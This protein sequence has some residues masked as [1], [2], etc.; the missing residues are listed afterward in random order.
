M[1][2]TTSRSRMARLRPRLDQR[3]TRVIA[4]AA[5]VYLG[6]FAAG[7]ALLVNIPLARAALTPEQ[8]GVWMM[9][10]ALMG[11]FAFA[12]LG[13]GNAVL[14]GTTAALARGDRAAAH[15]IVTGGYVW[16]AAT[17]LL[18]L[19]LWLVWSRFSAAPSSV[20]GTLPAAQVGAVLSALHAFVLLLAL[21]VPAAL[22][23]KVQLAAQQGSW[24]GNTQCCA[25][26]ATLLAVPAALYV[27]GGLL[28]LVFA[29]LGMQV[30]VNTA[31]SWLWLRRERLLPSRG[32]WP[33]GSTLRSLAHAGGLFFG[34]QIAAAFA[35]QSDAIVIT[36]LLGQREYGDFAVVQ[37]WFLLVTMVVTCAL[38]GLWPALGDAYAR[39]ES[40]WVRTALRRTYW[41]TGVST[42]LAAALL[43]ATIDWIVQRWLGVPL[44]VA[45]LMAATL[46][47]WCVVE[48]LG[49][50]TGTFLNSHNVVRVQVMLAIALAV[51]AF[52]AKWLLVPMLGAAGSVL[53]TLGAYLVISVPFQIWLVRRVLRSY[54][55]APAM[56]T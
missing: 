42:A 17:G 9:L 49:T 54:A 45:P 36:Q 15:R 44:R 30:L 11:F 23:Q 29:S 16:T 31:S 38:A 22:A 32:A 1:A 52:G 18:L 21:N 2:I 24:A 37:R 35:F 3:S 34:L 56:P 20:V 53:A 27:G 46:A 6:R 14:N 5:A 26:L 50:V 40:A 28:A 13:V 48:A 12:D 10:T 55:V 47:A 7:I 39:K 43:F 19:T 4:T 25:A 8:F 41:V 33:D 51:S